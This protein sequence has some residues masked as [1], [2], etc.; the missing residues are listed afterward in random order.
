VARRTDTP[1]TVRSLPK[2]RPI[3]AVD[4]HSAGYGGRARRG[5]GEAG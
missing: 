2:S 1:P 3:F 5:M 4:A